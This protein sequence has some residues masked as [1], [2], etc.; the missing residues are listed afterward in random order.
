LYWYKNRAEDQWNRIENPAMN[1]PQVC[2]PYF[3]KST[4]T[5]AAEKTTSSTNV[6]WK[7]G[8]LL[9]KNWN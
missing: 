7:S 2:P 5:Y 4:K 8:Y 9:A 6:V 3:I 1:P